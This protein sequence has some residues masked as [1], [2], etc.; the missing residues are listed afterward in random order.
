M[1]RVVHFMGRTVPCTRP[2]PSLPYPTLPYLIVL[3]RRTGNRETV[4]RG[5]SDEARGA[6][7]GPH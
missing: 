4:S 5:K 3:Y 6:L 2:D 7:H 1:K